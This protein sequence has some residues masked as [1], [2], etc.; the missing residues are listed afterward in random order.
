MK[1]QNIQN[2]KINTFKGTD[3]KEPPKQENSQDGNAFVYINPEIYKNLHKIKPFTILKDYKDRDCIKAKSLIIG[4]EIV[5]KYLRDENGKINSNLTRNF[6][7][8]YDSILAERRA[9]SKQNLLSYGIGKYNLEFMEDDGH[10][11]EAM[12]DMMAN[13]GN[14]IKTSDVI[15]IL[16][17]DLSQGLLAELE[18]SE[19]EDY[20][21]IPFYALDDTKFIFD[22]SKTEDVQ[23][24]L[25][26]TAVVF[27]HRIYHD[28]LDNLFSYLPIL[29]YENVDAN[30]VVHREFQD[31][32]IKHQ[33]VDV[34]NAI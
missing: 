18:K 7:E 28:F 15:R 10:D 6:I 16:G 27:G 31:Y 20:A 29:K 34:G 23:S 5:D 24:I 12:F 8:I 19:I 33:E 4:A 2:F 22:L 30:S 11:P 1:I 14:E 32:C 13:S 25:D 26:L 17:K 21:N 9:Q 3:K